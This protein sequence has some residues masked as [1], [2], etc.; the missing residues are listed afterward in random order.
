MNFNHIE[1]RK[2]HI[3]KILL[4]V[5][6][7][8]A[9]ATAGKVLAFAVTSLR[10]GPRIEA[11]VAQNGQNDESVKAGLADSR[12]AA[13]KLKQKNMFAEPKPKPKPPACSAI[14]GSKALINGKW[15]KTGDEVAGA[16]IVTIGP[17]D[18]TVLWQEKETKLIPFAD[19]GKKTQ[20]RPP[21]RPPKKARERGAQAARPA[22]GPAGERRPEERFGRGGMRGMGRFFENMSEEERQQ[23]RE[24]MMNMSPEERR[25]FFRQQR[26]KIDSEQNQR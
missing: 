13:D 1:N 24:K 21:S 22:G 4:I 20:D 14:L 10:I 12:A 17:K 7:L 3:S 19:S 26:E 5:S 16:K 8:F 6:L 11:A 23:L 18:V 9:V 2:E 15:Y 25:E